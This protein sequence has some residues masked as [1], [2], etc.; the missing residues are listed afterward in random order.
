V[1]RVLLVSYEYPPLGGGGGVILR[2]LARELA[3]RI[4]VTVLTTHRRGLAREEREGA[5]EIVRTPV[6]LR[7][8]DATAS[9]PSMLS[10][11][12]SSLLTGS[13]LLRQ[14]SYDLVHTSFAVPSGPGGLLLA[15]RFR[16]PHVL[17]IHG[18]D[19]WDPSKRLS[20]HRT[21]LLKQTVRRVLH[22][23]DRVVAQS[24]DTVRRARAIYG[25]RE[26]D[27][28]PLAINPPQVE[29]ASRAD[30]GL[31]PDAMLLATVGR[32]IPRK[33]LDDLIDLVAGIRDPRIHLLVIGEGPLREML[34][35]RARQLAPNRIHFTGFVAEERKW[36]LLAAA[37]LY[38]S[39]TL[40]EGF[41]IV[42]LEA[43]ASGLPV[44]CYDEGGQRDFLDETVGAL[45]PAGDLAAFRRR[46]EE[47]VG[48]PALRARK[49]EAGRLRAR[50]Y[51]MERF[52]QRYLEIYEQ[53]L[54][55][56]RAVGA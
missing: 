12:P 29:S 15:R 8:A 2:D 4:E 39:T 27:C 6:F 1:K 42:F 5:L 19:I 40:H 23:S 53:A 48:D 17:M 54:R 22:A 10:F 41:G 46:L 45:V 34:E 33:G 44:I 14:R 7:D 3:R 55:R 49:G 43:M 56:R 24:Q 18:G 47:H 25:A 30:L 38:V 13:R 32:L 50:E 51:S 20:P 11:P 26:V 28:V 16:L 37:D 9:L 52:A 36:Q 21:P 31:D 35:D